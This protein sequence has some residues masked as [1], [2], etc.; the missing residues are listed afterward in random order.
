MAHMRPV[1]AVWSQLP[2]A[3]RMDCGHRA[4]E[5]TMAM[6]ERVVRHLLCPQVVQ[7]PTRRDPV[8]DVSYVGH[9]KRVDVPYVGIAAAARALDGRAYSRVPQCCSLPRR[10]RPTDTYV[11]IHTCSVISCCEHAA[12]ILRALL[13]KR[14]MVM[15]RANYHIR[16]TRYTKEKPHAQAP[17]YTR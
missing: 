14:M 10:E 15:M 7:A 8:F 1:S 9:N 2:C 6:R 13:I 16:N 12:I 5:N 4:E 17:F 11:N 3:I